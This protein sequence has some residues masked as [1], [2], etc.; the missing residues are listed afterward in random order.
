M[1]VSLEVDP[2]FMREL[3]RTDPLRHAN[4]LQNMRRRAGANS[5][6]RPILLAYDELLANSRRRIRARS[7]W[8][9]G[10]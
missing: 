3:E 1:N 10:E 6:A 4:L 7:G 8:R 2:E 5:L 9:I